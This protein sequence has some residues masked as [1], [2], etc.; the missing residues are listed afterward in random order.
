MGKVAATR[1][2]ASASS[3]FRNQGESSMPIVPANICSI[4]TRYKTACKSAPGLQIRSK[5]CMSVAVDWPEGLAPRIVQ[6]LRRS[7]GATAGTGSLLANQESKSTVVPRGS[8]IVRVVRALIIHNPIA[9]AAKNT[10]QKTGLCNRLSHRLMS[11]C[12]PPP[13]LAVPALSC[14]V[15]RYNPMA[16]SIPTNEIPPTMKSTIP[17]SMPFVIHTV[18]LLRDGIGRMIHHP[19]LRVVKEYVCNSRVVS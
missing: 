11:Y 13:C 9:I 12:V 8:H 2:T 7:A 16:M 5:A 1:N 3:P 18:C 14:C 19:P 6:M 4:Q 15:S 17:S 10:A